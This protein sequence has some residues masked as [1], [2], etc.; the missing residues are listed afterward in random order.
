MTIR[1]IG[2]AGSFCAAK[3]TSTPLPPNACGHCSPWAIRAEVAVAYRVKQLR[4]LDSG[5]VAYAFNQGESSSIELR[6]RPRRR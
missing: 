6:G 3:S 4:T 2:P 5:F 1:S